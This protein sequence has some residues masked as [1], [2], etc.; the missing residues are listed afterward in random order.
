MDWEQIVYCCFEKNMDNV[1]YLKKEQREDPIR[2]RNFP[3]GCL[4]KLSSVSQEL[5]VIKNVI[6]RYQQ[7]EIPQEPKYLN[8]SPKHSNVHIVFLQH[9][10]KGGVGFHFIPGASSNYSE[11]TPVDLKQY[12]QQPVTIYDSKANGD[13]NSQLALLSVNSSYLLSN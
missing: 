10:P 5:R 4:P 2:N 12:L 8:M 3:L 13:M 1:I 7:S 11:D 9:I 6:S